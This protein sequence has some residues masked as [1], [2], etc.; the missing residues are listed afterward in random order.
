[1][2]NTKDDLLFAKKEKENKNMF[3]PKKLKWLLVQETLTTPQ[4]P[5]NEIHKL[6]DSEWILQWIQQ[7]SSFC[8]PVKTEPTKL[9]DKVV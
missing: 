2:T 9:N 6:T 1:M 7:R 8:A 4:T 3:S 5:I